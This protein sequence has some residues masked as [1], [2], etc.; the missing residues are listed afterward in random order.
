MK[1][2]HKEKVDLRE[3]ALTFSVAQVGN[4]PSLEKRSVGALVTGSFAD[5]QS[6][7]GFQ[8]ALQQ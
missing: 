5:F 3:K 6:A 1:C 7:A 8:P 2:S 4:L